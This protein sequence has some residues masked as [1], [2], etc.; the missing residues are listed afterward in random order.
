MKCEDKDQ[1]IIEKYSTKFYNYSI[2]KSINL[3][4]LIDKIIQIKNR[5]KRSKRVEKILD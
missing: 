2:N 1:K 5:K 4:V 3:E